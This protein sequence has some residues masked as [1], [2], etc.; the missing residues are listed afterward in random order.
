MT[1][2]LRAGISHFGARL[3]IGA[4]LLAL[5]HSQARSPQALEPA[6]TNPSTVLA[7]AS[8]VRPDQVQA[9]LALKASGVYDMPRA[10][11]LGSTT[12]RI[13]YHVVI[14]FQ[15]A[16]Q[17]Y[18]PAQL[19]AVT[20]KLSQAWA[21]SGLSFCY[22]DDYDTVVSPTYFDVNNQSE[23]DLLRG[24][25][26]VDNAINVYIVNGLVIGGS[27]LAGLSSFTFDSAQGIIMDDDYITPSVSDNVLAHE[28]GHYFDLFHTHE[29]AFGCELPNGA[30]CIPAGDQICDTPADPNLSTNNLVGSS[31][32]YNPP[33]NVL[34]DCNYILTAYNPLTTNIMS[35][36]TLGCMDAFTQGQFDRAFNT[37]L[38]LRPELQ[39]CP[40]IRNPEDLSPTGLGFNDEFGAAVALSGFA[41][42][43]GHAALVSA[44]K[45]DAGGV[46][47]GAIYTFDR[48]EGGDWM[49]SGKLVP[50]GVDPGDQL[51]KSLSF[52][53]FTALA[54]APFA[55]LSMGYVQAYELQ[56]GTWVEK[57]RFIEPLSLP[58]SQ[59]GSSV[60]VHGD[61]AVVGTPGYDTSTKT[62]LGAARVFWRQ[63]V[64]SSWLRDDLLLP[65]N[66]DQNF[67]KFGTSV[68]ISGWTIAVGEPGGGGQLSGSV[69]LFEYDG[70]SWVETQ[71]L[72]DPDNA[73]SDR[74][75]ITVSLHG[76][77]LAVGAPENDSAG[78]NTGRVWTYTRR[79]GTWF[80]EDT[81]NASQPEELAQFGRTVA[82]AG[83]SLLVGALGE[84][85]FDGG[86]YRFSRTVA[87]WTEEERLGCSE[88]NS[89]SSFGLA[90]D[91][92][93]EVR[94][95]ESDFLIGSPESSALAPGAGQAFGFQAE[96][97]PPGF[98][99]SAAPGTVS[100]T[101]GGLVSIGGDATSA[102]AGN[103]YLL[104]GSLS[105]SAPGIVIS[106]NAPIPSQLPVVRHDSFVLPL[107][108][109]SYFTLT[110]QSPNTLPLIDSLGS[111]SSSGQINSFVQIP[112]GGIL[113]SLSGTTVHHVF[114]LLDS[115]FYSSELTSFV[116][117]P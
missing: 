34:S 53:G 10:A 110:A 22:L 12:V 70:T 114:V 19:P 18:D 71:R 103:P 41:N 80:L 73:I 69:Y 44:P 100:V 3:L 63:G 64:S 79:N 74:F 45:D 9:A 61:W 39:G 40:C 102:Q 76:D 49:P 30:N 20:E 43:D 92:E 14:P 42:A 112:G 88:L 72:I 31:C 21:G 52:D 101:T 96:P 65:S 1:R 26:I 25:Q 24:L 28:V 107:N 6:Q 58:G 4:Q 105:G 38:T 99:A 95:S 90:L 46:D 75:G 86:V 89:N 2:T 15:G 23:A 60:D 116:L 59:F 66:Q 67:G 33:A 50:G 83:N 109:D 91:V 57:Q 68:S 93:D 78:L 94:E 7:C 87:G 17:Q 84:G 16:P 55:A 35:Y 117:V 51:G 77:T 27:P 54:G 82:L 81:L 13:A 5:G 115:R 104:L 37:Y 47:A 113:A 108:P 48:A 97:A 106:A 98:T 85:D 111:V 62:D 11:L 32:S 29:V 56:A 8:S 36:T